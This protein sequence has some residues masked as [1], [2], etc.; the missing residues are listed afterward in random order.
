M[1]PIC[2]TCGTQL[3]DTQEFPD[4]CP[5]CEDERQYVGFNGQRWTTL[6]DLRKDHTLKIQEE[7]QSLLSFSIEPDFGIGQ[8]AFLLQNSAGNVLWDCISL[9]NEPVIQRIRELGGLSAIAISHPHY[10]T[11]M[12]EWSRTFAGAPI[13]LHK[14]D[15]RWVMRPDDA[16]HFWDGESKA[17][18][19][20]LTVIRCGGHFD[21]AAVL[22]WPAGAGGN[23]VLLTGDTI[24]VVSDRRY[25]SF[26]RSYPNYI[27]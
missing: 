18:P 9:V 8:R 19:G 21:G 5:I 27:R 24:Q 7:E 15:A 22:H 12:V 11:A 16:I 17:L 2:I 10:Y 4:H 23:S 13:Y 14:A 1:N 3:A 25:V 6:E 26:M 20:G